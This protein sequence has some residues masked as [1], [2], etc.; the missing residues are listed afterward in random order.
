MSATETPS[1]APRGER[2]TT[3]SEQD[4][5]ARISL[6]HSLG[7]LRDYTVNDD[8]KAYHAD[9]IR[10]MFA[11]LRSALLD[12][13]RDGERETVALPRWIFD[14]IGELFLVGI[15]P[16]G[17]THVDGGHSEVVDV[18]RARELFQRLAAIRTPEGTRFVMVS[19]EEVPQFAGTLNEEAIVANNRAAALSARPTPAVSPEELAWVIVK[20]RAGELWYFTGVPT[21]IHRWSKDAGRA[22]RFANENDAARSRANGLMGTGDFNGSRVEQHMWVDASVPPA[23]SPEPTETDNG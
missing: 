8:L 6:D 16:N 18:A 3:P 20:D 4:D 19:I 22:R 10:K 2:E 23:A 12:R 13:H 21:A 14:H 15:E 11:S 17:K 9:K 1:S 5:D 7:V